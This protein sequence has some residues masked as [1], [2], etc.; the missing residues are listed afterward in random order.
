[1]NQ[2][3]IYNYFIHLFIIFTNLNSFFHS[4][5]HIIIILDSMIKQVFIKNLRG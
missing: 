3:K 2:K 4:H 1:M 5:I